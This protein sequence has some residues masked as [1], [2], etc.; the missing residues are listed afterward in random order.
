MDNASLQILGPA[1]IAGL[2]VLTSHVP[3]GRQVLGRGI[4]FID[5]AVAQAAATGALATTMLM[6]DAPAW[7]HQVSAAG[8]ALIMVI[9]L[10]QLEKR[11]P[12]IQE[13]LIGGSFVVLACFAV[14]LTASDPH[15]GEHISNLMAGQILWADPQQLW[16]LAAASG[17]AVT[18]MLLFRHPLLHFYL[19]FALAI[20]AAVQVVG[21]YL[22]F[23]SL[24]FPALS[25]RTL[26][27][28]F[29]PLIAIA[30]GAAGYLLGLWASLWFD[31]PSGPAV[32]MCLAGCSLAS[33]LFRH[34]ALTP[35]IRYNRQQ[36]ES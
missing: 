22:V 7:V 4:I 15:G 34:F 1:L 18:S 10:H 29:A 8:A 26:A 2:L 32:V 5:L 11:W 27:G 14:L 28:K 23:A 33:G 31:L 19:P 3:L 9:F 17:V 13:A 21:V 25:C 30:I 20:T 24:I 6:H 16:W 12:A 35:G 36:P